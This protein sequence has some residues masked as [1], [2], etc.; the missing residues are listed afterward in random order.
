VERPRN[1]FT[2][3]LEEW[4]H[5]CASGVD[6]LRPDNWERLP[7]RV[8][9]T[10]RLVLDLFDEAN[11]RATFFVV[12]WVAERHPE[13]IAAVRAAGHEIGSHSYLHRKLY[14][15][16]RASFRADLRASMRALADA[17]VGPVRM[18]RAPEWS[19]ND[20]S[21][22]ALE[23]L[24]DEGIRVD[25]SMAPV[26]LVGSPDYPRYPHVRNTDAGPIT[27]V[28]PLVADRF[29]HVMPMGWGWGLRMSSPGRILRTIDAANRAGL[30]AVLTIHPWELDPQPPRVK[31]PARLQF[32]HYFRLSGFGRRLRQVLRH[33]SFGRIGDMTPTS[34]T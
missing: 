5:V 2:V 21:L 14:E 26:K 13:L 20:R 11:V 28:P 15:L 10:T 3:D 9:L 34:G 32:A 31:L 8:V 17:G 23:V 27:E 24:A 30:P 16:D 29:G 19:I 12:G 18:F 4:F 1:V 33:G 6:A 22:W 7:S 25:A